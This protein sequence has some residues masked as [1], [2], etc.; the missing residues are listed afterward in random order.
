MK[1]YL[2]VQFHHN[3]PFLSSWDTTG[4]NVFVDVFWYTNDWDCVVCSV[5]VEIILFELF[6]CHEMTGN[7]HWKMVTQNKVLKY[8]F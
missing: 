2:H 4:G 6:I 7:L 5:C 3:C 1:T 8:I